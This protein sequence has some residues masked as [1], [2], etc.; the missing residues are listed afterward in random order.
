MGAGIPKE[1][2]YG[3]EENASK[4]SPEGQFRAGLSGLPPCFPNRMVQPEYEF[5][6]IFLVN[7]RDIDLTK[8][9]S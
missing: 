3:T 9:L 2:P 7:A 1:E 4:P 5:R 6:S 8:G